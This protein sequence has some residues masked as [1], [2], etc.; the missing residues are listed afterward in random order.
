MLTA[1][2]AEAIQGLLGDLPK[3]AGLRVSLAKPGNGTEP[4]FALCV[5]EAPAAD[6]DVVEVDEARVFLEPAASG[7]FDDKVLD[8]EGE[9]FTFRPAT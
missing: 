8:A 9:V 7:Y 1:A 6:D 3:G 5:A 4:E 2:A